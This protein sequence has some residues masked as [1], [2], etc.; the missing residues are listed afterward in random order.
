M[1]YFASRRTFLGAATGVAAGLAGCSETTEVPDSVDDGN[2]SADSGSLPAEL[3][4]GED[5]VVIDVSDVADG[6]ATMDSG[7]T[8]YYTDPFEFRFGVTGYYEGEAFVD[9]YAADGDDVAMQVAA[10]VP[11]DGV[12]SAFVAPVYHAD[13]ARFEY[14]VYANRPYVEHHDTHY[15][16]CGQQDDPDEWTASFSEVY[17]GVYRDAVT[18]P[19]TVEESSDVGGFV[20]GNLTAADVKNGNVD[21]FTG[22]LVSDE[23]ANDPTRTTATTE[24][25]VSQEP[26][27]LVVAVTGEQFQWRFELPDAGVSTVDELVVPANQP[28]FFEVTSAD[29]IHGFSVPAASVKVDALPDST[30]PARTIFDER[31]EYS[32][33]CTEYCGEGH[34]EMIG[35]ITAVGESEY[36]AWVAENAG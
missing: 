21:D 5:G 6:S 1:T 4:R 11:P 23:P 12:P 16:L 18:S 7:H 24:E 15:H 33:F 34:A 10:S 8:I 27:D 35:T 19:F 29:V 36:E 14:R 17:D 30:R 2:S 22:V 9:S 13:D 31:G 32:V 25:P 3:H 28:V 20:T 26:G